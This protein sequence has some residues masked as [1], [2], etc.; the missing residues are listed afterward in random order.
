MQNRCFR[1]NRTSHRRYHLHQN[2]VPIKHH[3][4]FRQVKRHFTKTSLRKASHAVSMGEDEGFWFNLALEII[5]TPSKRGKTLACPVPN[6][7]ILVGV[8]RPQ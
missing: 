7:V 2:V 5:R 8:D 1:R 3:M 4:Q 6:V